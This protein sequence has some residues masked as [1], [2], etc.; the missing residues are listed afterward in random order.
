VAF[1]ERERRGTALERAVEAESTAVV[2]LAPEGGLRPVTGQGH[3]LMGSPVESR[4]LLAWA[5]NQAARVRAGY[6]AAGVYSSPR[7]T[8]R[9]VP[10]GQGQDDLI[11]LRVPGPPDP[12]AALLA[13]GLSPREAEVLLRVAG[14]GSN[15][16]I[17]EEM[18]VRPSTVKKHLEHVYAKLGVHTRTAAA[19]LARSVRAGS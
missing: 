19:A 15:R 3:A 10:G 6:V 13:L 16:E 12:E 1:S 17:A 2:S 8:A 14:G 7:L 5:R 11:L 4:R 18:D 9:F